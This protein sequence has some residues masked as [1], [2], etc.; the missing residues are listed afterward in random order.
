MVI[1]QVSQGIHPE[2]HSRRIWA[3]LKPWSTCFTLSH[4]DMGRSFI[5]YLSPKRHVSKSVPFAIK[6]FRQR[7]FLHFPSGDVEQWPLTLESSGCPV[8]TTY[9]CPHLLQVTREIILE[10]LQEAVQF[11]LNTWRVVWL[12]NSSVAVNIGHVLQPAA[13]QGHFPGGSCL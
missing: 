2:V 11:V 7:R 9:Y 10:D 3:P 5:F 6:V 1:E 4:G 13:P 12:V 8:A